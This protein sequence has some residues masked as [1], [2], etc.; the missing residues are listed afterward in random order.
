MNITPEMVQQ[1]GLA[2]VSIVGALTT[3]VLIPVAVQVLPIV[4]TSVAPMVRGKIKNAKDR[5]AFDAVSRA[6]VRASSVAADVYGRALERARDPSSVGGAFVLQEEK[7]KALVEASNAAWEDLQ[8]QG[9]LSQ[10]VEAYGGEKAVRQAVNA[11]VKNAL[12]GKPQG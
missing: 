12:F 5:V 3:A 9:L 6:G 7:D 4:L 10:V 11:I 8:R 2:F 1:Y